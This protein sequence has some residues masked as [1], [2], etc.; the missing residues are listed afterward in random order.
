MQDCQETFL[1]HL[2]FPKRSG[3][4]TITLFGKAAILTSRERYAGRFNKRCQILPRNIPKT[5]GKH[6]KQQLDESKDSNNK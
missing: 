2:T 4:I 3:N 1:E 6:L 5:F